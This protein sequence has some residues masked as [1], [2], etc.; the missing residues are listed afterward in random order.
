MALLLLALSTIQGQ[1]KPQRQAR[2]TRASWEVEITGPIDFTA[3][4]NDSL[5]GLLL[6]HL[7]THPISIQP[8]RRDKV[9][10]AT[11]RI[12][13]ANDMQA[14]LR[15]RAAHHISCLPPTYRIDISM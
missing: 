9:R 12:E 15:Q 1:A 4:N 7:A 13:I 14:E 3:V 11:P 6:S 10:L 5:A 2:S 8:W